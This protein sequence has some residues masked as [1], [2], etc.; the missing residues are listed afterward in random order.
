MSKILTVTFDGSVLRPDIPPDLE[1]NKRYVITIVSEDISSSQIK[2]TDVWDVL[3]DLTGTVDAPEDW[4][5][6]HDDYLYSTPKR[7]PEINT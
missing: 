1:P 5:S 2:I 4:A 7:Q 6:Q 3:E